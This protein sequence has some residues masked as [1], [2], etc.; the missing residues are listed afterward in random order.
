MAIVGP[1]EIKDFA[2]LVNKCWLMEE[3]NMKLVAA[4]FA[5]GNFKKGL[6]SQGLMFKPIYQ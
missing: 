5:S 2:T 3:C 6:V 1:M 4:K